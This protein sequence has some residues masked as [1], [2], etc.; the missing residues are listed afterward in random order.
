MGRKLRGLYYATALL[1]RVSS[2][3][4]TQS[5]RQALFSKYFVLGVQVSSKEDAE[6]D[7]KYKAQAMVDTYL[8]NQ[9]AKHVNFKELGP[10]SRDLGVQESAY[11]NMSSPMDKAYQVRLFLR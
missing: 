7:G 10:M 6:D 4:S 3:E 2:I 5:N 9:I 8:L 11:I 1:L